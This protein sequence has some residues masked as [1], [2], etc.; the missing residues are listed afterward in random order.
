M[1]EMKINLSTHQIWL[2]SD[3]EGLDKVF[4]NGLMI[5]AVCRGAKRAIDIMAIV[6]RKQTGNNEVVSLAAL[7]PELATIGMGMRPD[8]SK[9]YA[10][11]Q[12]YVRKR[13]D[14]VRGLGM[15]FALSSPGR[16]TIQNEKDIRN[17]LEKFLYSRF[18][19]GDVLL[20]IKVQLVGLSIDD[21]IFTGETNKRDKP[22]THKPDSPPPAQTPGLVEY[23]SEME[24][25]LARSPLLDR[26]GIRMDDVR[27]PLQVVSY[28]S[29]VSLQEIQAREHFRQF[30]TGDSDH[31]TRARIWAFRGSDTGISPYAIPE[32]LETVEPRLLQAVILGDP[33]SGKTEWMKHTARHYAS[34]LKTN[35][36]RPEKPGPA[37]TL[38]VFV[39]LPDLARELGNEKQLIALIREIS[40]ERTAP[41]VLSD[42]ERLASAL[43]TTLIRTFPIVRQWAGV[44]WDSLRHP[45]SNF[46]KNM[47]VTL[48]LDAW[49]EVRR[50]RVR[51]SDCLRAFADSSPARILITSRIVGY[52]TPLQSSSTAK[53]QPVE[54]QICPFST[55]DTQ[56]FVQSFFSKQPKHASTM[57]VELGNKPSVAGMAQNPLLATLLCKSF[58]PEIKASANGLPARR[59][60][61]F[62]KV[63]KGLLGEWRSMDKRDH[64]T[65]EALASK[66]RIL[67]D[68]AYHFFPNEAI[69]VE[70]LNE[71]LWDEGTGLMS[72][73][74]PSHPLKAQ[75]KATDSSGLPDELLKD[76]ILVPI[77]DP[78][79]AYMFLHLTFHEY[80]TACALARRENWI[81]R[82]NAYIF[83]PV[84]TEPLAL[85]AGISGANSPPYLAHLLRRNSGDLVFRPL[86]LA[87]RGTAEVTPSFLPPDFERRFYDCILSTFAHN[88]PWQR[89]EFFLELLRMWGPRSLPFLKPYLTGTDSQ[90]QQAAIVLLGE[91][92]EAGL[93]ELMP[94]LPLLCVLNKPALHIAQQVLARIGSPLAIPTLLEMMDDPDPITRQF[95]AYGF[96]K[97][98]ESSL[99]HL[100][101]FLKHKDGIKRQ[102]AL[103]MMAYIM[104]PTVLPHVAPFLRNARAI[105]QD[106]LCN[107][108]AAAGLSGT[109]EAVPLIEPFL[110]HRVTRV[111]LTAIKAMGNNESGAAAAA[112]R[113]LLR[114]AS[115]KIL[116]C[117]IDNLAKIKPREAVEIFVP[118]LN[119]ADP[120]V[121]TAAVN[122]IGINKE[123]KDVSVLSRLLQDANAKVRT[124]TVATIGKIQPPN[125]FIL[126]SPMLH[127]PN[128]TVRK[129]VLENLGNDSPSFLNLIMNFLTDKDEQIRRTAIQRLGQLGTQDSVKVLRPLLAHKDQF[130]QLSAGVAIAEIGRRTHAPVAWEEVSP[131]I[132]Q[133]MVSF[134]ST[135]E[136]LVRLCEK[137]ESF[138]SVE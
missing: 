136:A 55:K 96:G 131:M 8:D 134:R 57:L 29:S 81:Q 23:L 115:P 45:V 10:K 118:F 129:T 36:F 109:P 41:P 62:E 13:W 68:I 85:V 46:G 104:T 76:G 60:E 53:G 26:L 11:I 122:V 130:T 90:M 56:S 108:I 2:Q 32:L 39:R 121:R 30:N 27:M 75:I 14:G 38:P 59:V 69:L 97:I 20:T 77:G 80:L 79:T 54:Y 1:R 24:R 126:L 78:P 132:N 7:A 83:D 44:L 50:D 28:E 110:R 135:L 19:D 58:A 125:T 114:S 89:P 82:A 67:E 123:F 137:Q 107:A 43:I 71:V 113:P 3:L 116:E 21:I 17:I 49:D 48:F 51:L 72:K 86:E 47:A 88:C 117:T 4:A 31:G 105:S 111:K 61:V 128:P 124:A 98:G 102:R 74:D 15:G 87:M 34:L 119:H 35:L 65:P 5:T 18:E 93:N 37:G 127:D 63:L 92:G 73:L 22:H 52:E 94:I 16:T 106:I 95:A 101:P 12:G 120:A 112:L 64:I 84:W 70:E 9:A 100:V 40:R 66:T 33:G 133:E 25:H 103:A 42:A 99:P 6:A 91:M 138:I